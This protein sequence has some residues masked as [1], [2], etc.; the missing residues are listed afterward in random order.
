ML[1]EVAPRNLAYFEIVQQSELGNDV[2]VYRRRWAQLDTEQAHDAEFS[3]LAREVEMLPPPKESRWKEPSKLVDILA[4][5]AAD[6]SQP[7]AVSDNVV[8]QVTG[9]WRGRIVGNMLG[10]PLE[11]S[12]VWN[13]TTIRKY[14]ESVDAYP[15]IDYVP[16][17]AETAS[18]LGFKDC[19]PDT[20]LGRI[21]G[22]SR[23][24]DIDYTILGLHI[25]ERYGVDYTRADVATEWLLRLPYHQVF[26][27][28]RAAYRNLVNGLPPELAAHRYNPYR[29]WIGALIRADIFGY[30]RPG[31]PRQAATLAYPDASLSHTGNGIYG[32]MWA[33][34]LVALAFTTADPHTVIEMSLQHVPPR[35]RLASEIRLVLHDHRGGFTWEDAVG[36]VETRHAAT[37]SIHTVNNAGI[38]CAGL[39][40]GQG[41][42]TA[43]VALTVQGGLDTDSNAA[44][45]GSVVGAQ[46]GTA[47]I[48]EHWLT[49]LNDVV[50]SAVQGFDGISITELSRRTVALI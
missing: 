23:D 14:L 49:P 9:A 21:N 37:N 15:L 41:D 4:T 38:I 8:D 44:T 25:L 1:P 3:A 10:K 35:S 6:T 16:V 29:E 36:R 42:F 33:A 17:Q 45:A 32:E 11:R 47:G 24:D 5:L 18:E 12:D 20:T 27:A 40:W 28:E 7:L 39:L 31:A 19:W 2:A 50:H 46:A 13:R 43:T 22:T 34:A 30:V 48:P 26:T